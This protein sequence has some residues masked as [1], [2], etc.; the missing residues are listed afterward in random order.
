MRSS[1]HGLD[2]SHETRLSR[3]AD[4]STALSLLSDE[5]LRE[6]VDD[7]TVL[8]TDIGG[9]TALL[10]L[11]NTSIFVKMIPIAELE[12]RKE[13][14]MSTRNVFELPPFF[15]YG[16]GSV[17]F[18]VW[19]EVAAHTITTNWVLAKKCESFPFMYHWRVLPRMKRSS[20]MDD[21]QMIAFWGSDAVRDRL[22]KMKQSVDCVVLFCEYFPYNLHEW[23]I[24]QVQI[25]EDAATSAFA[26]VES[27]LR[28]AVSFMNANEL[29]HFDAHFRNILTD[30]N[31]VYISDFGLATSSRFELS[32]REL[33][34]LEWNKTHDGCYVVTELV[35]W[36]AR[37]L[38]GATKQTEVIDFIRQYADGAKSPEIIESATAIIKR[39]A[40]IAMVMNEFYMSLVEKSRDTPFP[41][42][43]IQ[44]ICEKTG[45]RP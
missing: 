24:E 22:E 43:K 20:T 38:G 32:D 37:V 3:Y 7:A 21:P 39:Y 8:G 5:Q 40:P 18:G 26:M 9:T 29:Q 28:S 27:N 13:N 42:E 34:F 35:N 45:F 2:V 33:A 15:H 30:G 23:L 19:R 31:R 17:G 11:D 16:I 1:L 14:M 25:G 4:V 36:M 44:S 41:A 10:Q 6:R 12:R